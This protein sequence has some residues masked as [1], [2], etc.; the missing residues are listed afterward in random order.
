[1]MPWEHAIIGYIG[2]SIIVRLF[3]QDP[4]TSVE[5]ALVIFA[6]LLPDLIDKPLAWQFNV[7]SS[8]HAVGHS[9]FFAVPV[10]AVVLLLAWRRGKSRLG[11]AF[12]VGFLFHLWGDVF[13]QYLR[14]GTLELHRL[15]WPVRHEGSG[16]DTGF[17]RELEENLVEYAGWIVEQLASGNPDPYLL[18]LL[19][20]AGFGLLLWI[21]DGMPIGREVYRVF[22]QALDER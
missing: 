5:A 7:F 9:L 8:G 21:A 18:V 10:S 20:L 6:S 12:G 2:Y 3:H 15:L 16:Y 11:I 17:L 1:M 13:P 22:R 19:G 4:P 14:T